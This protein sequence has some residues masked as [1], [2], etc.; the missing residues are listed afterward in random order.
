MPGDNVTGTGSGASGV[1]E[2]HHRR[3]TGITLGQ[4]L[5]CCRVIN[6]ISDDHD[7]WDDDDDNAAEWPGLS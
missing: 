7:D 5:E 4:L 2:G 6:I 3:P 1:S